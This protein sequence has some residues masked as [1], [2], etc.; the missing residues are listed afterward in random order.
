M[1]DIKPFE[2]DR[3]VL[4]S[5]DGQH[6]SYTTSLLRLMGY[7]N[8]YALRWGMSGWNKSLLNQAG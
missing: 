5:N 4:V 3:I 8:V 6:A 7:G 1:T 2:F